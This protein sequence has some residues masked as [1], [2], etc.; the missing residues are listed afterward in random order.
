MVDI[1]QCNG[2]V[3]LKIRVQPKS[4]KNAFVG[5]F[6]DALKISVTAPPVDSEANKVLCEFIA[7]RFKLPKSAVSVLVGETSRNKIVA[8]ENIT[9]EKLRAELSI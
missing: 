5:E 8:I 4:S 3:T 7:K 1:K 2:Y 6:D 9:A